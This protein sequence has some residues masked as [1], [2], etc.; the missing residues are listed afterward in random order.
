VIIRKALLPSAEEIAKFKQGQVKPTPVP[1]PAQTTPAA[2]QDQR[3]GSMP[4]INVAQPLSPD[5][6]QDRR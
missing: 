6:A 2:P 3:V 4:T 1:L 5:Q